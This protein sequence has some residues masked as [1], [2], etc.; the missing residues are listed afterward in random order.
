MGS[1]RTE[2]QSI[3]LSPLAQDAAVGPPLLGNSAALLNGV[4]VRLSVVVGEAVATLGDLMAL[5]EASILKL[6]R[7][8]DAPVDVLVNGT[9]VAR[10]QLVAIDEEFGVRLT[11]V[12]KLV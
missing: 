11:E 10:G 4:S 5:R 2:A 7:P 12:A 9:V 3:E 1:S 8:V 6:D